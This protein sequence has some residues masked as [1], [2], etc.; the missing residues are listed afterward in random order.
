MWS[1]VENTTC[2]VCNSSSYIYNTQFV[3]TGYEL[4]SGACYIRY[5][6]DNPRSIYCTVC[7]TGFTVTPSGMCQCANMS[8]NGCI[9]PTGFVY[10]Q[11]KGCIQNMDVCINRN[12][13]TG[14]C[15]QCPVQYESINGEC[16]A[17]FCLKWNFIYPHVTKCESCYPNF[18]LKDGF[19]TSTLCLNYTTKSGYLFPQC[20]ACAEGYTPFSNICVPVYC[21][22]NT[23]DLAK[24]LCVNCTE[25]GYVLSA[26][27]TRCVMINCGNFKAPSTCIACLPGYELRNNICQ[28]R[29]CTT[30]S[31]S[32][33]CTTCAPGYYLNGSLCYAYGCANY[34]SNLWCVTCNDGFVL[35]KNLTCVRINCAIDSKDKC[36]QCN[37]GFIY[38][39]SSLKCVPSNCQKFTP[40]LDGC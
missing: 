18:V 2:K 3:T 1:D 27:A 6:Q 24:G 33:N 16:V 28:S 17:M 8:N 29:N 15:Y 39:S 19:C 4:V 37:R 31:A 14:A 32:Y 13:N 34:D 36:L 23:Y 22:T 38:D 26:D 40:S 30:W 12:P 25:K 20:T 35:V 21:D 11:D 5:C 10:D 7:V 9:C